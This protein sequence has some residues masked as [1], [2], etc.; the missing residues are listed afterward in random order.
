M[1]KDKGIS[2]SGTGDLSAQERLEKKKKKKKRKIVLTVIISILAVLIIA[3][4]IIAFVVTR[5][6]KKMAG[7]TVTLE[8]PGQGDISAEINVNGTLESEKTIHYTAP[9]SM[10]VAEVVPTGSFVKKGDVILKFDEDSYA[11]ALRQLEINSKVSANTYQSQKASSSDVRNK[12]AKAQAEANKYQAEANAAQQKADQYQAVVDSYEKDGKLNK[13]SADV[14]TQI[15]LE[16]ANIA[17]DQAFQEQMLEAFKESEEY[18]ALSNEE[19]AEALAAFMKS[20]EYKALSD[21][22]AKSQAVINS[23]SRQVN[24]QSSDYSKAQTELAKYKAEVETNKAKVEQAKAEVETYQKSLGNSYDRESANLQEELSTI[25]AQDSME[26]LLKYEKGLIAPFDGVVTMVSYTEGDTATMGTPIITFS[27]LDDVHVT[28]GVGKSDL[29]KIA[30]GMPVTIKML[31]NEYKGTITTIN[32]SAVQ[33]GNAGAQVMV[34]VSVDNPDDN[35]YLGLDAKCSILTGSATNVMT[36]PV[37]AV[38]IDGTGEFVF[39]FDSTTMMVK[40]KY[41]TTGTSSDLLVEITEGIDA[42]DLVVVSYSGV[43]EDGKMAT[44]SPES[45]LLIQGNK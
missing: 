20:G 23:V 8:K 35:I 45:M 3:V 15:A 26:E 41:V 18:V 36:L 10:V 12:I 22:I 2:L 34:T 31:K 30:E 38:N 11:K 17:K 39:T 25:Q 29:E 9:A 21:D 16:Q 28:L 24:D 44:P 1:A 40:K 19:K 37:E 14:Q 42:N 32:R 4:G 5:T 6:M 27:S 13:F 43:L 33:S 7:S